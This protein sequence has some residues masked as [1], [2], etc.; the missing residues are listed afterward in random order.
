M[1]GNNASCALVAAAGDQ[2][3]TSGNP[4]NPKIGPLQNNGGATLTHAP[5]AGSPLIDAGHPGAA[6][7]GDPSCEA[8][9]QVGTSRPQGPRCDIGAVE[10]AVSI[11]APVLNNLAPASAKAGGAGF[12]LTVQGANFIN[13]TI[14]RWNGAARPTTL[15]S[16]TELTAAILASDI[17]RAGTASV[18]IANPASL[19]GESSAQGFTITPGPAYIPFVVR[20]L[21]PRC[22]AYEPNDDRKV[23]PTGPLLSGVLYRAKLCADDAEDNYYFDTPTKTPVQIAISI[24]PHLVQH[25]AI[26]IYAQSALAFP[27]TTDS[28]YMNPVA[29]GQFASSCSLP[30]GGRYIVR[31]YTT[32]SAFDNSTDY[33]LQVSYQ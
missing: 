26:G 2:I 5:L 13:G 32:E 33:T 10:F 6:G 27:L 3:G 23:D 31:L 17:R 21:P 29:S 4:L 18:T 24:P 1:I 9:D 15:V 25:L 22:D 16:S 8:T 20:T 30:A 11:P 14:V 28:C 12:L 7:Q 19:G